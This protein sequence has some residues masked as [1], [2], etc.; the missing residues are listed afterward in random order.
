[1]PTATCTCGKVRLAIAAE[2]IVTSICHCTSC[3]TAGR[4]FEGLPGAP[5]VLDDWGGVDVTLYR[6]DAVTCEAGRD[7][8]QDHR[9]K[10]DSPTRRVLATCCN[11]PMFS[12][13]APGFWIGIYTA[14]LPA[15]RPPATMRLMTGD[16]PP[17]NP[18]P[19]DMPTFR[20]RPLRFMARLL[21]AWAGIG[22]RRPA[23]RM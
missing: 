19:G 11:A 14:R 7:L 6:R 4:G 23:P 15:P 12:D 17:G 20:G 9:L 18:L 3:R 16:L 10:P 22:F 1:M 8:L 21:A 5:K 2:P 13:Y